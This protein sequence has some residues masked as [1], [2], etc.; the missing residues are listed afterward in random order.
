[1]ALATSGSALWLAI[2]HSHC[3]VVTIPL[4]RGALDTDL[5]GVC[6]STQFLDAERQL[7]PQPDRLRPVALEPDDVIATR[8]LEPE[9]AP[10]WHRLPPE[11]T[12]RDLTL[13]AVIEVANERERVGSEGLLV[14]ARHSI[15]AGANA[16][17]RPGRSPA[18]RGLYGL[19]A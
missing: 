12:F 7:D 19:A 15:R 1:M 8:A 17:G 2:S 11:A 13:D 4:M 18:V 9:L 10:T 5:D 14:K 3:R 6:E 16:R